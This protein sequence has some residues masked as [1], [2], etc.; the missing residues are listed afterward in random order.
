MQDREEMKQKLFHVVFES[1]YIKPVM[2]VTREEVVKIIKELEEFDHIK[3]KE[4]VLKQNFYP[5][6]EDCFPV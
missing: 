1:G 3:I 2:A 6:N 5:Y 4:I